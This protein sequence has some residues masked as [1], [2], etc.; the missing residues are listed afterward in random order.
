MYNNEYTK[1]KDA[2]KKKNLGFKAKSEVKF[3]FRNLAFMTIFLQ[4]GIS[5]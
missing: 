4:N 1:S 2:Y 3:F 5:Q